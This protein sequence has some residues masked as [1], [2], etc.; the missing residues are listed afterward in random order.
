[1]RSVAL[2]T[3]ISLAGCSFIWTDPMKRPTTAPAN[4]Q[5]IAPVCSSSYGAPATDVLLA[6]IGFLASLGYLFTAAQETNWAREDLAMS[7][8]WLAV[9]SI[10]ATSAVVGH[11]R[12]QECRAT[13]RLKP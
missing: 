13:F 3:A 4:P 9:G 8:G 2:L 6:S 10:F 11:T 5:D 7:G 1:M 12:V